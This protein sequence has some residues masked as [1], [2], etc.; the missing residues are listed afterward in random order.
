LPFFDLPLPELRRD[1]EGG[2]GFHD[3]ARLAWLAER[4]AG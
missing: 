4:F 1:H 3:L 2:Q